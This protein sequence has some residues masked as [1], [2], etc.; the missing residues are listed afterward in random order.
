[1]SP[2][3]DGLREVLRQ[4]PVLA[5]TS[6][7]FDP[8]SAPEDPVELFTAWFTH[9]VSAGVAEPQ[10]MTV[11]T[12]DEYSRPSARVLI[13]KDVDEAGWHF[14]VSAVSR[15]GR[16]LDANPVAALTFYWTQLGRSADPGLRP[17]S[18]GFPQRRAG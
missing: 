17:G 1:M 18:P 11:S 14:A 16:E 13:L 4:L 5:G 7:T 10:S 9:A 2:A 8:A 6:S 12:V 15:K 3:S